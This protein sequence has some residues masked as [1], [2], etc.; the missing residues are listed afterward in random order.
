MS[1]FPYIFG[2]PTKPCFKCNL[3]L[4]ELRNAF[5]KATPERKK[6]FIDWL[7]GEKE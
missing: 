5:R 7:T 6:E 2:S 4:R 1:L 3:L